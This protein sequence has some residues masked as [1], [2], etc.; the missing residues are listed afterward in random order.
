MRKMIRNLTNVITLSRLVGAGCLAWTV[1]FSADFYMIYT[2]CG[3]TDALDGFLA[4]TMHV[5]SELGSRLDSIGDLLFYGVAVFLMLPFLSVNLPT[6]V[7]QGMWL[8]LAI[9]LVSYGLAAFRY[10]RF[11]SL[12]TWGNKLSGA[13]VFSFPYLIQWISVRTAG[14][15]VIVIA[16]LS[17]LEELMIHMTAESYCPDRKSIFRKKIEVRK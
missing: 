10:R 12:H 6:L 14:S 13:A 1:P 4:R 9:R 2:F 3:I 8:I 5:E 16:L 11:A 17:S 15:I 7:W